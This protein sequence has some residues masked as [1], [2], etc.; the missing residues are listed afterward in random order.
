MEEESTRTVRAA[1]GEV[2]ARPGRFCARY[3][4]RARPFLE[5]SKAGGPVALR[6]PTQGGRAW[7]ELGIHPAR[8]DRPTRPRGAGAAHGTWA[9][10]QDACPR[11]CAWRACRR[12]EAAHRFRREHDRGE[13]PRRFPVPAA[14]KGPAFRPGNGQNWDRLFSGQP[15]GVGGGDHPV[16]LG[17]RIGQIEKTPW[18]GTR[19]GCRVTGGEPLAGPVSIV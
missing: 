7:G 12:G 10:G 6:R 18:R 14:G 17:E 3:R 2:G 5:T 11:C 13:F 19:A 4:E 8:R 15:E 16:K 9:P 1:L